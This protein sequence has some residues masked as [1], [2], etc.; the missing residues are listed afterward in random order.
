MAHINRRYIDKHWMMFILR[1]V[2]AGVFGL[3]LL[4]GGLVNLEEVI[5]MI[6]IF[7]LAMGIVDSAGAL[8][9]SAK[10]RGWV[11]SI[12]DAIID[13]VAALALLFLA[14]NNLVMGLVIISA[15]VF[16]SGVIDICHA[17]FSTVDPT[18]RSIRV[19]AGALGFVMG[20]VILNAGTFEVE[21]FIRFFGVY[22]VIVGVTS[23]IYGAHNRAQGI[24]DKVAR[25]E[26][27]KKPAKKSAKKSTKKK[28]AKKGKK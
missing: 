1:G 26:A 9:N 27:R 18:D 20:C 2:L 23:M 11:T 12:I 7:L 10:R 16:L 8:Y 21:M 24:E 6:S 5:S 4:F 22:M 19:I 17:L 3:L 13:I 25:S 15:Y 28:V 14:S